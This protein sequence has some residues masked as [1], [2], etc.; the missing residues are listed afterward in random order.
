MNIIKELFL[1]TNC[2]IEM[3]DF[4]ELI[5]IINTIEEEGNLNSDN[6]DCPPSQV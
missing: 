2:F 6:V 3:K 4:Y 5:A 1:L